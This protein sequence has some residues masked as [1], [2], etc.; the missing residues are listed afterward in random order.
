MNPLLDRID[1][2]EPSNRDRSLCPDAMGSVDRL[3]FHRGVPPAIEEKYVTC[4]LK[5]EP[6]AARSVRHEDHVAV[7]IIAELFNDRV[8]L[9][10][11]NLAVVFDR[12]KPSQAGPQFGE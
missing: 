10:I 7:R 12:I 3:V 9:A 1:S 2:E 6:N 8:A 4:E 5:I 11:R